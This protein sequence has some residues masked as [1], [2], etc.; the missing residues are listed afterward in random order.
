M[1]ST[2]VRRGR[3]PPPVRARVVTNRWKPVPCV[4]VARGR[5]DRA[6]QES[7]VDRRNLRDGRMQ[8]AEE[9]RVYAK[10]QPLFTKFTKLQT[11]IAKPLEGYFLVF[12]ANMSMQ[13]L[14]AK[15]LEILLHL[16]HLLLCGCCGLCRPSPAAM[17][18]TIVEKFHLLL[19]G[20]CGLCRPSPAAM[21][22][23]IVEKFLSKALFSF[24][25]KIFSSIPSNL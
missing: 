6:R 18:L 22:L 12:F 15:P 4:F 1:L 20:C 17:R 13:S 9:V 14:F 25:P 24:P 3:V 2:R 11:S 19:C 10:P 7:D 23:T 5:G 16:L 21:R 8:S